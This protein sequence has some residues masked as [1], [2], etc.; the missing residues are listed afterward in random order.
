[1]RPILLAVS[2]RFA[3]IAASS[4]CPFVLARPKYL[5]WR[6]PNCINLASR[7]SAA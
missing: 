5:A 3:T 7:C 4:N 6:I 2:V 1:M